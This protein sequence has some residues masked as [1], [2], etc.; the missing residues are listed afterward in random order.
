MILCGADYGSVEEIL[1]DVEVARRITV[2][3]EEH[4]QFDREFL[5]TFRG[6]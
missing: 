5:M 4:L 6:G 1:G 2:E 3:G